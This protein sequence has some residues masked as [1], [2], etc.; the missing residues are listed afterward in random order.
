MRERH[1]HL[2][3]TGPSGTFATTGNTTATGNQE[4]TTAPPVQR[5]R[6]FGSY[7]IVATSSSFN[8]SLSMT[9]TSAGL[10]TSVIAISGANQSSTVGATDANVLTAK[11]TDSAGHPVEG[12]PVTFTLASGPKGAVHRWRALHQ[13]DDELIRRGHIFALA[14]GSPSSDRESPGVG[15]GR[16]RSHEAQVFAQRARRPRFMSVPCALFLPAAIRST[17]AGRRRRPWR[18]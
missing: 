17:R 6:H 13:R 4:A 2:T 18:W 5:Q 16:H 1:L 3:G 10:A 11:V 15:G 9:D 14:T 7:T 12:A 8:A